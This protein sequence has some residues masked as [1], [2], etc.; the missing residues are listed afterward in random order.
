MKKKKPMP[1]RPSL[2]SGF[3][4]RQTALN[5]RENIPVLIA[6]VPRPCMNWCWW[7]SHVAA[8]PQ[9]LK[10]LWGGLCREGWGGK[11][12]KKHILTPHAHFLSSVF[13][14]RT[15]VG[16]WKCASH[17]SLY[18][19]QQQWCWISLHKSVSTFLVIEGNISMTNWPA[20]T[21]LTTF[22]S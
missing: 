7:H 6:A 2:R 21:S 10:L 15:F 17:P 8:M 11:E 5:Y 16:S 18:R 19:T 1:P 12:G 9:W 22:A 20:S 14:V 13:F 4:A 3:T